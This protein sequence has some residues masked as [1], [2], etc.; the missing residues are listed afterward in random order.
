[1]Q[2]KHCQCFGKCASGQ[3]RF[4]FCFNFD[5][6]YEYPMREWL[7]NITCLLPKCFS[8]NLVSMT[9]LILYFLHINVPL[10]QY[11]RSSQKKFGSH[12]PLFLSARSLNHSLM[13]VWLK[14]IFHGHGHNSF[15]EQLAWQEVDE[16]EIKLLKGMKREASQK[17][18]KGAEEEQMWR[19]FI[20]VSKYSLN[21]CQCSV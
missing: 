7:A 17:H 13:R 21:S 9:L 15:G 11:Y 8:N 10:N 3:A 16:N 6:S 20:Y 19:K 5:F 14:V 12:G 2:V 4:G 1:M 18:E